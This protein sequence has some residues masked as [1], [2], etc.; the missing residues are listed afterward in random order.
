MDLSVN[1]IRFSQYFQDYYEE[2]KKKLSDSFEITL[3]NK[4]LPEQ[5]RIDIN[6]K[7]DV[8]FGKMEKVKVLVLSQLENNLNE[9]RDEDDIDTKNRKLF[10]NDF[11]CLIENKNYKQNHKMLLFVYWYRYIPIQTQRLPIKVIQNNDLD[12]KSLDFPTKHRDYLD[13]NVINSAYHFH[14]SQLITNDKIIFVNFR[15]DMKIVEHLTVS[16]E[17]N[18]Q[19]VL[20]YR[21]EHN[22]EN[23][24]AIY[25]YEL[26]PEN[27]ANDILPKLELSFCC[28]EKPNNNYFEGLIYLEKLVL[29][30]TTFGMVRKG[31]L[32]GLF[33][34][35]NLIIFNNKWGFIDRFTINETIN[36]FC[37]TIDQETFT[38]NKNLISLDLDNTIV[39][40]INEL[41]FMNFKCLTSIRLIGINIS[42]IRQKTFL[43]LVNLIKLN[44][45]KNQIS[46]IEYDSFVSLRNLEEL[47]LSS[48]VIS[49]VES[50][51]FNGLE[52]LKILDLCKNKTEINIEDEI[53][54]FFRNFKIKLIR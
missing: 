52:N 34:L 22:L 24:R 37:S 48:N 20:S 14:K 51:M 10:T 28:I 13:A 44:L 15:D 6:L 27:I 12:F 2:I 17:G 49:N 50:R 18:L 23:L 8:I 30:E 41:A 5:Q 39:Q 43:G 11:F 53:F 47:D 1:R 29:Y 36:E 26:Q 46:T 16:N 35:Q 19:D 45:S 38:D 4:E 25:L 7:H 3:S 54:G 31:F 9:F 32:K 40:K 42:T 33:S 21:N